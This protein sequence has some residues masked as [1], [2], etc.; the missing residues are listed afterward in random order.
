MSTEDLAFAPIGE[1]APLIQEG[2]LSPVELT[3]H[4]L[5]RIESYDPHLQSYVT[6]TPGE[7]SFPPGSVSADHALSRVFTYVAYDR[8]NAGPIGSCPSRLT[9]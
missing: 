3:H 4:F 6:S 8:Q 1:L 9:I 7:R 2:E 5:Q